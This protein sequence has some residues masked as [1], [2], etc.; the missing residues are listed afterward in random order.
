M[1]ESSNDENTIP[2]LCSIVNENTIQSNNSCEY[3]VKF[4]EKSFVLTCECDSMI[5]EL[6]QMFLWR[7]IFSA[8]TLADGK[9]EFNFH[10]LK[11]YVLQM[12]NRISLNF[13]NNK[14][15]YKLNDVPVCKSSNDYI[16]ICYNVLYVAIKRKHDLTNHVTKLFD[17][18]ITI[19]RL[20]SDS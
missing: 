19:F 18:L 9:N 12:G 2:Q 8:K 11:L 13:K 15:S 3:P 10:R 1:S 5:V 17:C 14:I 16:F 4:Y 20:I 6:N 7:L